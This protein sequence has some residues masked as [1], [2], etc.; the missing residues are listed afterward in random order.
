ME[1]GLS[2][3]FD[4]MRCE[5]DGATWNCVS[6]DEAGQ[7]ECPLVAPEPED[8]CVPAEALPCTY[9]RPLALLVCYAC[10][11]DRGWLCGV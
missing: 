8:P 11:D 4:P 3:T 1:V 10:N 7:T 6:S 2:V 5:C 9:A